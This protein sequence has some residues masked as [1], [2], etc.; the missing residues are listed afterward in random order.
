MPTHLPFLVVLV[1]LGLAAPAAGAGDA[2]DDSRVADGAP[3]GAGTV[4]EGSASERST[5]DPGPRL[6]IYRSQRWSRAYY[7]D[8]DAYANPIQ[9]LLR[10]RVA[11]GV[12][13]G[14]GYRI[15]AA[16]FASVVGHSERVALL[17]HRRTV[18]VAAGGALGGAG[19]GLLIGG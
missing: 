5:P 15:P 16:Q 17:R 2:P 11:W 9:S 13:D 6:A 8:R 12:F 4:D 3:V 14:D 19:L 7:P 1:C 10:P 18:A